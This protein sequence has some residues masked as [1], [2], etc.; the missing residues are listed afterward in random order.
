MWNIFPMEGVAKE[1][2]GLLKRSIS[3]FAVLNFD[4]LA[5]LEM[6]ERTKAKSIYI[7]IWRRCDGSISNLES[8]TENEIPEG[9]NFKMNYNDSFVP[10]S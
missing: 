7:R 10:F 8:W 6:K 9:V 1:K 2:A 3:D 5:V 4:D